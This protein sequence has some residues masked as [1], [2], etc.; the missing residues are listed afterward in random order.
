[1][2]PTPRGA[3]G[4]GLGAV[5]LALLPQFAPSYYVELATTAL[6]AAML[7]L[8]LQLLVGCTGLVSLGLWHDD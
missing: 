1:M 6:I 5:A 2:L 4:L 3:I 7:A 8:S